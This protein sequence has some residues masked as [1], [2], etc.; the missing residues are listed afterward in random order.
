[1]TRVFYTYRNAD[2]T[3]IP[4]CFEF[5]GPQD[6]AEST[7]KLTF[8]G[9]SCKLVEVKSFAGL[10]DVAAELNDVRSRLAKI[11]TILADLRSDLAD[12]ADALER[13]LMA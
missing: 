13:E 11:P 10:H 1:M 5:S 12:Y 3:K 9:S 4:A 8:A 7:L 6:E 2:R